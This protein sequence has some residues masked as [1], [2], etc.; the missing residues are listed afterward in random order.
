MDGIRSWLLNSAASFQNVRSRVPTALDNPLS[1]KL[2][3]GLAVVALILVGYAY[4]PASA[5]RGK[6]ARAEVAPI[7][8]AQAPTA[9][10]E[11]RIP[12]PEPANVPPLTQR[13]L[14]AAK[15]KDSSRSIEALVPVPEPAGVPP[16]TI[17]TIGSEKD[18]T[19]TVV[20]TPAPANTET[21]GSS[22][23]AAS[24]T[25][26]P[27]SREEIKKLTGK[28][29]VKAPLSASL[30]VADH[31]TAEKLRDILAGRLDRFVPRREDRQAVEVFY[32]DRGFA[33]L[34]IENG[35]RTA[36]T[37]SAIKY[38]AGVNA[39]G[40]EPSD[41]PVPNFA[42]VDA[43]SL[44]EAELKF[45]NSVLDFVRHADS[46]RVHFTRVSGDIFYHLDLPD[47]ADTL[48]K[49]AGTNDSASILASHLPQ[50]EAYKAL[51]A[52]L[53]EARGLPQVREPDVVRIAEGP[54]LKPGMEDARVA[55]LRKRLNVS[56]D[57]NDW[58][59]DRGV[60]EAVV[61][62]QK[63]AGL[64]PDGLAGPA[65]IRALNGNQRRP[66]NKVDAIL[67]TMERW[68]WM[69]HDLGRSHSILN[70]PDFT[71]KVVKNGSVAWQTRVVVGKPS[72]QTP[73]ISDTMKF[74][75]VNPTWNV[76]PSIIAN[77][78]LPA[79]QQD[80]TVLDRMGLRIEEN[81]D[82]T[83]RIYQPP[84]D[85]NALGRLRFNFPNKFLVYQH[86]TPDKNLFAKEVRAYSHGCMRVQ[87]PVKYAEV[88]LSIVLP[89]ENYTQDRLR[90]MFG[91]GELNINF[92]Q[93]LPVHI[94]Y[95]TAFVDSS[96][97][98][99]LRDDV[100]GHDQRL[101][102]IMRGGERRIADVPLA[103]PKVAISREELRMP[104]GMYYGAVGGGRYGGRGYG[105]N[106]F[107]DFF[108][109][110]FR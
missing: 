107:E 43:Q 18:T 38:L 32:R 3:G 62:F 29:L 1:R 90:G 87:D 12:I 57:L 58:R 59:Y 108:R 40:L 11:V 53:A 83:V 93:P 67:A 78:Y 8:L 104:N 42:A 97:E 6:S 68:R 33:P 71:L 94:T 21:S 47:P 99:Q 28:D 30:P 82:G 16:L 26:P 81:R 45:T 103:R 5:D 77:E 92:P 14:E 76:P 63:S 17:N 80:P 60:A 35:A 46:G 96:G 88:L 106:P 89:K 48:T 100:Y 51:K 72:M 69:P 84:G 70:I 98:L 102:A 7:V 13:D 79:L 10:V 20:A 95:Q 75:T 41:Y 25:P 49:L 9:R 65:T 54:S 101:L 39:D 55:L 109:S 2:A 110:I 22:A 37:E 61:N 24:E 4:G 85:S 73:L 86:D 105:N 23:A 44:A 56:G 19:A 36:R 50:H 34:W 27:L 52:K 64:N 15:P 91:P 74:I 31:G 66:T